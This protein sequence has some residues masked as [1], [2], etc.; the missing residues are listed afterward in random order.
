MQ[1]RGVTILKSSNIQK[2]QKFKKKKQKKKQKSHMKFNSEM[3]YFW[4]QNGP[5]NITRQL[6]HTI[7]EII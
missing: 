3:I 2:K 5:V 4:I 1:G 7:V 6:K